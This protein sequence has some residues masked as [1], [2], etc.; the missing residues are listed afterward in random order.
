VVEVQQSPPP[1]ALE[2]Y[3]NTKQQVCFANLA[4]P[5]PFG[6]EGPRPLEIM[7]R[8]LITNEGF[9]PI[10]FVTMKARRGQMELGGKRYDVLLGHNY[11][12]AG[13]SDQP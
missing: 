8:L 5:L 13:W 2:R 12:A 10:T 3:P 9:K 7:P 6:S 11:V 1:G 4:V